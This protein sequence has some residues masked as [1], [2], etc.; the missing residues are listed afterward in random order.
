MRFLSI[1]VLENSI[2][3]RLI[4]LWRHRFIKA[5]R[6]TFLEAGCHMGICTKSHLNRG[7]TKPFLDCL[8]VDALLE[9]Q[10][11]AGVPGIVESSTCHA[12]TN[13]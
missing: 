7:M 1:I 5:L 6:R 10:T 3:N 12:S 13:R 2:S 11:G 8:R 4:I 9:H